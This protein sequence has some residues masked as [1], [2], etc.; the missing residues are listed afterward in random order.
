MCN[1][2]LC[3]KDYGYIWSVFHQEQALSRRDSSQKREKI[4]AEGVKNLSLIN[5][6]W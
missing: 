6:L 5:P 2:S 1:I 3:T 4:F